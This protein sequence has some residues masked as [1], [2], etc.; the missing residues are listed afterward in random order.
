MK[1]LFLTRH[2]LDQMLGG[3]NCSK[4]FACAIASIFN[5]ATIIYPEHNETDSNLTIFNDYPNLK[6]I[7]VRDKRNKFQKVLDVYCGRLHRFTS[8]VSKFLKE[9][10]F[11]IIFIDHSLTASSGIMRSAIAN[12]SRIITFHHNVEEQYY[13]DNKPSILYRIPYIYYALKAEHEA[14][15]NSDINITLTE[16]DKIYFQQ[17]FPNKKDT[18]YNIGIF[19]YEKGESTLI[20]KNEDMTFVISGSLSSKQSETAIINFIKYYLPILNSIC[21]KANITITGRNPSKHLLEII[22]KHDNIKTV[23]NPPNLS[24]VISQNNFYICPIFTGGGLKLRCLDAFR[25]GLPTISHIVSAR[26]Y[27]PM[28]NEG[29]MKIYSN[30]AEFANKLTELLGL[31][32]CHKQVRRCFFSY[33]ALA[34]GT[35]RLKQILERN[36]ILHK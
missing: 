23:I 9:N 29:F 26:G 21:P 28:C 20:S 30:Q 34:S 12:Q 25:V 7:P 19:E 35:E 16:E 36:N 5:D 18:F 3:P 32:H 22:K 14:L 1:V 4:A 6:L 15:L 13:K 10:S 33:Y 8:F 17:K 27:E 2:Y 24:K 31:H 11:D